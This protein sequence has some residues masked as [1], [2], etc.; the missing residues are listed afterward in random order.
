MQT[1]TWPRVI[2]FLLLIMDYALTGK[3][4]ET[5]FANLDVHYNVFNSAIVLV[6]SYN[7]TIVK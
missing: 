3:L 7:R 4:V 1:H 2:S 6:Q 5:N